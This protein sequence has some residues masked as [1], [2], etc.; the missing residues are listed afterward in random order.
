MPIKRRFGVGVGAY[1]GLKH[2]KRIFKAEKMGTTKRTKAATPRKSKTV[3]ERQ[4]SIPKRPVERETIKLVGLDLW[5]KGHT[6]THI[7]KELEKHD[8]KVSIATLSNYVQAFLAEYRDERIKQ[9]DTQIQAEL[10]RLDKLERTYWEAWERSQGVFTSRTVGGWE[11]GLDTKELK[12]GVNNIALN[13][14]TNTVVK[15]NT[16][17]AK[18][19]RVNKK[20]VT[21]NESPS[22][23][24]VRFLMGVER[25]IDKRCKLLGLDAP[26]VIEDKTKTMVK[27]TI[28]INVQRPE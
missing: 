17:K 16:A 18:A 20:Y 24:D 14:E 25:V 7:V 23:G 2:V 22:V 21:Y 3:A 4:A 1:R 11:S 12:A 26:L 5:L 6:L 13:E 9:K 28:N 27:R 19:Q 15:G 10:M 8:L